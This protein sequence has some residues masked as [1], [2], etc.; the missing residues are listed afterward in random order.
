MEAVNVHSLYLIVSD[1]QA[2]S[3]RKLQDSEVNGTV[4][5]VNLT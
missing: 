3:G 2:T 1:V 4:Y 5:A